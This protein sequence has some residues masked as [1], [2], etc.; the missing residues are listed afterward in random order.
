MATRKGAPEGD[1]DRVVFSREDLQ[2]FMRSVAV[3]AVRAAATAREEVNAGKADD[4]NFLASLIPLTAED[5]EQALREHIQGLTDEQRRAREQSIRSV[6]AS[7][8]P[9]PT[10]G[11]DDQPGTLVVVGK[12]TA[13][14]PVMAKRR[15]T[16]EWINAN[17]PMTTLFVDVVPRGGVIVRGVRYDLIRGENRVPSL[18]AEQYANW[19]GTQDRI[20]ATYPPLTAPEEE[21]IKFALAKGAK[22]APTRMHQVGVGIL[23]PD[24]FPVAAE[25]QE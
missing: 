14:M 1:D 22:M 10:V 12:D 20:E 3:E 2:E 18:V 15:A 16:K 19:R 17:Y 25:R 4:S 9:A 8:G 21:A 24:V 6:Y 7:L 13:G 23:P 5:R 11:N